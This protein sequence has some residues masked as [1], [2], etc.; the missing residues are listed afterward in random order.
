MK[1]LHIPIHLYIQYYRRGWNR[2]AN[3]TVDGTNILLLYSHAYMM[4]KHG[5]RVDVEEREKC[6]YSEI[7]IHAL[8]SRMYVCILL[9]LHNL[10]TVYL[11]GQNQDPAHQ[12]Q[13]REC[14][15]TPHLHQCNQTNR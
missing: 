5:V 7:H 15:A 3:M 14:I 1:W 11:T 9:Y 6:I 2:R 8:Y 10:C 13:H 4:D 12:Q